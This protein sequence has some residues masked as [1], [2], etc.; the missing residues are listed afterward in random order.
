MHVTHDVTSTEVVLLYS[1]RAMAIGAIT[2]AVA[3]EFY[4]D[5]LDEARKVDERIEARKQGTDKSTPGLLEGIPV[6]V[7]DAFD[8]KGADTTCGFAVRCFKPHSEDGLLVRLLRDAGAI[9]YV[10]TNI[11]QGLMVPESMN[12]IWGTTSN[13]WNLDRTP[14]GSSGGEGAL[15]A[16]R[17]SVLGVGSDI[18]GSLRIPSAFCGLYTIKPTPL[19]LTLDGLAFPC[20]G[21]YQTA[22]RPVAGPMAHC[23]DDLERMLR[24]WL[25]DAMWK[26]D[27]LIPRL[28]LNESVLTG[29]S[30]PK[31]LKIGYYET[32]GWF[33]AAP[34]CARA[35]RQAVAALQ[36]LGHECVKWTPPAIPT[37]VRVYYGI[38]SAD[39]A[40]GVISGMEGEEVNENY[41]NLL[42]MLKVPK[43]IKSLLIQICRLPQVQ[44]LRA[45][46][47]L[48]ALHPKGGEELYE[49]NALMNEVIA[50]VTAAWQA[51][52]LDAVICPGFGTPALLHGGSKDLTIAASYTFFWNIMHYPAGSVPIGLTEDHEVKYESG[53]R[54][55]FHAKAVEHVAG[56]VGM[57]V[58]VQVVGLPFQ[59]EMVLRVMRDLERKIQFHSIPEMANQ[60]Q[61]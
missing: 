40:Q 20:I 37:S 28:P 30:G 33:D 1:L 44:Q 13:P 14:G 36:E 5:A 47:M 46:L 21:G 3:E 4:T 31:K 38:M 22:V 16:A 24:C 9:L 12:I 58:G 41:Q 17:G 42:L 32:D 35:V 61:V 55:A 56:S 57:P 52:E 2:N 25:T 51:E 48:A 54:D 7:K 26:E 27:P 19:R 53:I 59:D 45:A 50:Q 23:V 29:K 8:Q 34:A 10:R 18:G 49:Y 11:P 43:W 15:L 60:L 6:S 39:S